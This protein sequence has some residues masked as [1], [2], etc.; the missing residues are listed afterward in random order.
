VEYIV[1]HDAAIPAKDLRRYQE[2]VR[3]HPELA[4]VSVDLGMNASV[5]AAFGPGSLSRREL[6]SWRLALDSC[7]HWPDSTD[8]SKVHLD[9]AYPPWPPEF[10]FEDGQVLSDALTTICGGFVGFW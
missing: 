3:K 4:R 7:E 5:I 1:V 6:P 2:L 9:D 8:A 10:T